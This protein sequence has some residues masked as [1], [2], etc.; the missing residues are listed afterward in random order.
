MAPKSISVAQTYRRTDGGD[1]NI[2]DAFLKKCGDKNAAS[3]SEVLA[4]LSE[5]ELQISARG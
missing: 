3:V 4:L 2:P 1:C 5:F